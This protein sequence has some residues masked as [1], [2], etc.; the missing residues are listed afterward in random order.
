M[1]IVLALIK[2]RSVKKMYTAILYRGLYFIYKGVYIAEIN[3]EI[4]IY[5]LP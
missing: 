5:N 4:E 3:R 1:S 2:R